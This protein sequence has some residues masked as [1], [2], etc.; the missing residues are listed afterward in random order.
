MSE[1]SQLILLQINMEKLRP[2]EREQEY[3][4]E[5]QVEHAA[6]QKD[7]MFDAYQN[8]SPQQPNNPYYMQGYNSVRK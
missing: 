2:E 7:G 1:V 4:E 3:Y 8:E 5:M 6:Q